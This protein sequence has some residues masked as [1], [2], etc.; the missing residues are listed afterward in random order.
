MFKGEVKIFG[1]NGPIFL[2]PNERFGV[3]SFFL[4]EPG[5]SFIIKL[6]VYNSSYKHKFERNGSYIQILVCKM[7]NRYYFSR[8]IPLASASLEESNMI[9]WLGICSLHSEQ[10][11]SRSTHSC[12]SVILEARISVRC[13]MHD[14]PIVHFRYTVIDRPIVHFLSHTNIG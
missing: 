12:E 1:K 4:E 14:G 11:A 9:L 6:V 5:F 10:G 8:M 2:G 13:Y 3:W 7:G